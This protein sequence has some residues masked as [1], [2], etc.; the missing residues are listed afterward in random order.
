MQETHNPVLSLTLSRSSG[1]STLIPS[2][3]NCENDPVVGRVQAR[4]PP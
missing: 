4:T 2:R 3:A 1:P